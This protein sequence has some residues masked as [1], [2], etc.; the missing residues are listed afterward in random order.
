MNHSRVPG[1][2]ERKRE[3]TRLR[4]A[5]E[6]ARLATERGVAGVTV[7]EIADAADISRATFFRFFATKETAIAE[8]FSGPQVEQL[9]EVLR[10]QPAEL[11]PMA[12]V[13]QSFRDLGQLLDADTRAL[14]LEQARIARDSPALQA[15]MASAWLHDEEL[16]AAVLAER[17]DTDV[18]DPDARMVAAVAM[19]ALRT[20]LE[21]WV[22]RDGAA[23]LALLFEDALSAVHSGDRP[24][25]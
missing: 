14:V 7:D 18:H 21:R 16:V 23:D 24:P 20:G 19:A 10:A 3:A 4:I 1:L 12:A 2:R 9:L 13:A 25:R 5:T 11:A 6:A 17:L 15:W 8:G 22:A